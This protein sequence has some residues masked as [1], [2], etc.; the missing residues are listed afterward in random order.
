MQSKSTICTVFEGHY[1]KGGAVLINSLY[2]HG[3]EGVVW[4]GY[5]GAL[6][7]WAKI[8]S[9]T[10][11]VEKMTV[12]T[13]LILHF[14][15]FPK[16]LFLPYSK[17]NFMLDIFDVYMPNI[18]NVLY[19]D[20]DIV[21]KCRFSYFEEWL[22]YGVALC[23]DMNSP[24]SSTHPIRY[25]WA[26]YFKKYG[27]IVK[28]KDNQYVNGG[29]VGTNRSNKSFLT[30][31]KQV[32]ELMQEDFKEIGDIS[33][34][35]STYRFHR[36]DQDAL[37]IAKDTTTEILSIAD[38]GAMDFNGIGYIMSHAAGK[39]KPW[40]N[41]WLVGVFKYGLR[42]SPTDRLFMNNTTFPINIYTR[43]E[44]VAK[45]MHLKLA[46]AFARVMA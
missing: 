31:W 1:H 45:K 2:A 30:T 3:Y 16:E 14:V 33:I 34:S 5:K 15:R 17:P 4:I 6:P 24:F 25:Q 20:C 7:P 22:G 46:T 35:D 23:E 37:N 13:N 27:I 19:I 40:V 10:E 43:S 9:D 38:G 18:E 12:C 41:N 28:N 8:E 44:R 42:P 29:F 21:V 26:K 32:Q 36:T 11:G 39:T